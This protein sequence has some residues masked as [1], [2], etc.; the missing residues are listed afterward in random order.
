MSTSRPRD[1][2]IRLALLIAILVLLPLLLVLFV[3]ELMDVVL[4]WI[5]TRT[6]RSLPIVWAF[7][8]MVLLLVAVLGL[9]Y[10]FSRSIE[11]VA[12]SRLDPALEELRIAYARGEITREEFRE[13]RTVLRGEHGESS[14]ELHRAGGQKSG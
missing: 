10:V 4:I 2:P 5:L 9:G 1:T 7:A 14:T 11:S 3:L 6:A 13:R 8:L 12:T